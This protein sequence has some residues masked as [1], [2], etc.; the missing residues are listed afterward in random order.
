MIEIF[1]CLKANYSF[2]IPAAGAHNNSIA[3]NDDI[4]GPGSTG[5]EDDRSAR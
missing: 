2:F 4:A 1:D 5:R 3:S